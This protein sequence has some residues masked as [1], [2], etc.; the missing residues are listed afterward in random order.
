MIAKLGEWY[1]IVTID[2]RHE[3]LEKRQNA[4]EKIIETLT[5]KN[6]ID[7]LLQ[8]I[9]GIGWHFRP[10]TPIV[11]FLMSELQNTDLTFATELMDCETELQVVAS[12]VLYEIIT[13]GSKGSSIVNKFSPV[14]VLTGFNLRKELATENIHY[15]SMMS[16]LVDISKT[17]ILRIS[18]K[19]RKRPNI[20]VDHIK[21]KEVLTGGQNLEENNSQILISNIEK[22][23]TTFQKQIIALDESSRIEY[24][25][26]NL[27]WWLFAKRSSSTNELFSDINLPV[28]ILIGAFELADISIIPP[29]PTSIDILLDAVSAYR[30]G[31]KK[32]TFDEMVAAWSQ[33]S[34]SQIMFNLSGMDK[35]S[36]Y[37]AVFPVSWILRR[38]YESQGQI[39]WANEF[40]S[41]TG[42]DVHFPLDLTIWAEQILW[43]RICWRLVSNVR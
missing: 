18:E 13:R 10:D 20:S 28:A 4:I 40:S 7:L 21:I 26:L 35:M 8:L 3:V 11:N 27:L 5:S 37:P 24:E 30:D 23:L 6:E 39:E 33:R 41:N 14:F 2:L 16:T 42:I 32:I 29:Y 17:S 38:F 9:S 1:R 34:I 36:T 25:E 15:G 22:V 43:E 19:N 31:D 12:L